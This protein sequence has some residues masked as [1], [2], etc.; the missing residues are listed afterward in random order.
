ML[1][2]P[3]MRHVT[4]EELLLDFYGE[5][6]A[7]D[8]TRVRNHLEQCDECRALDQELRTVLAA[9][10]STPITEPPSGFEREMWARI[11][12][13]LPVRQAWR[14]RWSGMV[15]RL[16]V[17]ASIGVLMVAAFAAG[18]IWDRPAAE[19]STRGV[20]DQSTNERLLRAEL[21]DH[22]ERSQR[23]LA[24]LVNA[25]YELGAPIAGDR[26]RA[27][28]LVAAG[29]LYRRSAEQMGDSEIGSL[30]E[31]LER[32]LVE[33]ANGP[34]DIA[35]ADLARWRQRIDDQDLVFRVRVVAREFG[36]RAR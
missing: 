35:P 15:P 4:D 26:A 1:P 18:R 9:V 31:D 32:V 20:D 3:M 33:V 13:L 10:E 2:E 23:V 5:G 21:E 29:R 8:R 24:E 25:D 30:L 11:A 14:T 28:D 34:P 17:A 22:L 27:A 7:I 12:P 36:E 6:T 16:A 19:P